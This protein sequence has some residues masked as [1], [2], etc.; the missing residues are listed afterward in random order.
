MYIIGFDGGGGDGLGVGSA[1][2]RS[3]SLRE[4]RSSHGAALS[5]PDP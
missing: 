2:A 4:L 3:E 5:R 1:L